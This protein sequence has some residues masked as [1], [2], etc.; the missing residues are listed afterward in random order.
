[1]ISRIVLVLP[2]ERL[3]FDI[4]LERVVQILLALHVQLDVVEV[5]RARRL[6]VDVRAT[7][8]RFHLTLE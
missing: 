4:V 6:E 8:V 3:H 5:L 7:N 2:I 1:M